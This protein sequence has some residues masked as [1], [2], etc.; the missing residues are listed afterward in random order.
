ML[1]FCYNKLMMNKRT[2]IALV[3]RAV[4][5]K[6]TVG[7]YLEKNYG[8]TQVVTGQL[9]RDYIAENNLGEPNRDL[10]I[11]VGNELRTKYGADY[12]VRKALQTETDKLIVNGT[13]A[14]G[15]VNAVRKAGG[16]VIATEAPME[17]RYEWTTGRGRISD[18]ISFEDFVRQEKLESANKSASAQSIDEVIAGADYTIQNDQDLPTLFAKV[19][20]LMTKL[21]IEK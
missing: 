13:R 7:A 20:L 16:I 5:G 18:K 6:D 10:M 12:L 19:D 14:V 3:G 21:G 1:L 17:K 4:S 9:I 11:R 8:F 2:I 15:E